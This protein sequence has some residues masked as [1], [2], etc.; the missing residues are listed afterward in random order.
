M[1]QEY[2]Q[3]VKT[4]LLDQLESIGIYKD[5]GCIVDDYLNY[6]SCKTLET[7]C[8]TVESIQLLLGD[9]LCIKTTSQWLS[10]TFYKITEEKAQMI[11]FNFNKKW[12]NQNTVIF[13]YKGE[14]Y[15]YDHRLLKLEISNNHGLT[16]N[17]VLLKEFE[18][19]H[20]FNTY[21]HGYL[22]DTIRQTIYAV[23]I[24]QL[25]NGDNTPKKIEVENVDNA[26]AYLSN[27]LDAIIRCTPP[28]YTYWFIYDD[29]FYKYTRDTNLL[30]NCDEC[31]YTCSK[32]TVQVCRC[33]VSVVKS[34]WFKPVYQHYAF[35][36]SNIKAEMIYNITD[37]LMCAIDSSGYYH[38][39]LLM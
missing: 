1:A 6:K 17:V 11:Y 18:F 38:I 21:V 24:D 14:I 37:R 23:K 4:Q 29:K 27:N 12:F 19:G 39:M 28:E 31:N 13:E 26:E 2:N 35:E 9:I 32:N 30:C 5:I 36:L 20:Y 10:H 7:R 34:N 15:G 8:A 22:M 33:R 25:I 3:T 16:Y